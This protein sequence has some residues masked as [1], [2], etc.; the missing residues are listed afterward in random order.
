[1]IWE[2]VP[3][4]REFLGPMVKWYRHARISFDMP[5]LASSY[6]A[7]AKDLGISKRIFK[8]II[9]ENR[10]RKFFNNDRLQEC[11][12][13][14]REICDDCSDPAVAELSV[15]FGNLDYRFESNQGSI[16]KARLLLP[17]RFAQFDD[18]KTNLE[19]MCMHP[20]ACS[21]DALYAHD[22]NHAYLGKEHGLFVE[23]K[24]TLVELFGADDVDTFLAFKFFEPRIYRTDHFF[25][26]YERCARENIVY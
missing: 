14:F 6:S 21:K 25:K 4:I 13:E 2:K 11:L 26:K 1:M 23:I 3:E 20:D 18:L 5:E 15:W 16:K 7:L 22:I 12:T 10:E 9:E 24:K 8:Q 17:K 19:C